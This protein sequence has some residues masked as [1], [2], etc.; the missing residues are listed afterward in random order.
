VTSYDI[1]LGASGLNAPGKVAGPCY[2]IR[3]R[4]TVSSKYSDGTV[5]KNGGDLGSELL[6]EN[7]PSISQRLTGTLDRETTHIRL[8]VENLTCYL[9]NQVREDYDSGWIKVSDPYPTGDVSLNVNAWTL[10]TETAAFDYELTVSGHGA[11]QFVG[12]CYGNACR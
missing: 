9:C 5:D 8:Q 2:N 1:S 3:C 10:N 4:W 12:P 7:T 11:A 6:P